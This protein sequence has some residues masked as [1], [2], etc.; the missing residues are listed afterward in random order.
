MIALG[1]HAPGRWNKTE[2]AKDHRLGQQLTVGY[3]L[4]ASFSTGCIELLISL[5][6]FASFQ[7]LDC[8]PGQ[9]PECEESRIGPLLKCKTLVAVV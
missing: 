7:S 3:E 5:L 6:P 8:S 1:L 2:Q 4:S 9:V